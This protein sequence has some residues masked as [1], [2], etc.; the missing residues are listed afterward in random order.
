MITYSSNL[1][2]NVIAI[3]VYAVLNLYGLWT[4]RKIDPAVIEEAKAHRVE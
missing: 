2:L 3:I 1:V 4:L